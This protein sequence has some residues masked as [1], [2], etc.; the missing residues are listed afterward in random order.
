MPYDIKSIMSKL[1][2][3]LDQLSGFEIIADGINKSTQVEEHLYQVILFD[4][5]LYYIFF[6][7]TNDLSGKSIQEIKNAVRTFKLK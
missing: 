3:T 2:I 4:N 1:P 5:D 6:G 7:T